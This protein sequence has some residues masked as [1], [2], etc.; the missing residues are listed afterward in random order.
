MKT[1]RLLSLFFITVLLLTACNLLSRP[2]PKRPPLKFAY[3]S[4]PG[5]FPIAIAKEKGFFTAQG[6]NVETFI[7]E[8]GQGIIPDFG[9]GKFDGICSSLGEIVPIAVANPNIRL[10]LM[11]DES[12][13]ADAVVA[14]PQI[15]NIADLN[16]KTIG[17]GL[18]SFGELFVTR[19]LEMNDITSS[20]VTLVNADGEQISERFKS[21]AIQAGHS[22]EP[23][24]AQMVKTGIRV[25]FTSKQTPG[26]IPDVMTFQGKVLRD[27]PDDIRAFIRAWFQAVEYWQTNPEEGNTIIGKVLNIPPETVS[28][29]GV[30]LLTLKDNKQAFTPGDTTDSLYYTAQL[31]TKFFVRTGGLTR[32]PDINQLLDPSFLK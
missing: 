30:K 23:H 20:Q 27:R 12:A 5:Y 1:Q 19:M 18:G 28:L 11:M 24:V 22:W 32:L 10:V 2:Q 9:A 14:Q 29:E 26:L 25:L 16:G 31:Y 7:R 17:V 3:S 8:N 15:Q 4:W 13:G 21:N 6:V